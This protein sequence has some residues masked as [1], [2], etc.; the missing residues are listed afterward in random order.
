MKNVFK[1][2]TK[3]ILMVAL[4]ATVSGFADEAKILVDKGSKKT[5]LI[6][7]DVKKGNQISIKD[8]NG[9]ILYSE[10]VETTGTYKKGFDLEALPDG[11][12]FFLVEKDLEYNTIPF[13][14][15]GS[16]VVF[17]K[18]KEAKF[19]KP[20]TRKENDM[21]YI[22]K[23]S[24]KNETVS[25]SIYADHNNGLQLRHTE[26]IVDEQVLERAY[27]L[28]KGNYKIVINSNNKEYTTFINN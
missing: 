22:T 8:E 10:L 1:K 14:V 23:F 15:E 19:F 6:L 12:Y 25:I 5:A 16:K 11:N 24:P 21:V 7:N 3:G 9:I 18:E 2:T 28:E 13:S 17:N 4:L 27:K 26:K 20:F